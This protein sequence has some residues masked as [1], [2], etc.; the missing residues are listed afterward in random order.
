[1]GD[2]Y[3]SIYNEDEIDLKKPIDWFYDDYVTNLSK[4]LENEKKLEDVCTKLNKLKYNNKNAAISFLTIIFSIDRRL[5]IYV[6]PEETIEFMNSNY[7]SNYL[8]EILHSTT[9]KNLNDLDKN[10]M[11]SLMDH[12]HELE[13]LHLYKLY[14][15]KCLNK[16]S[17]DIIKDSNI[18]PKDE[19]V[20]HLCY[21]LGILQ[22]NPFEP[23]ANDLK[24]QI[25]SYEKMKFY[26]K[27]LTID[28]DWALSCYNYISSFPSKTVLEFIESMK[29]LFLTF[30]KKKVITK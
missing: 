29:T 19:L 21:M 15:F 24:R 23:N 20:D 7:F 25:S 17:I 3:M 5:P 26:N 16:T 10:E 1:M 8:E 6:Y 13:P 11:L 14:L 4:Y 9:R 22:D 28:E 27:L 30:D 18:F 2:D 12:C